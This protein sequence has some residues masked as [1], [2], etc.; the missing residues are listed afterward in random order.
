MTHQSIHPS[1]L[2]ELSARI[3][4]RDRQVL[5]DLGRVRLATA[6]Q[7]Q[8]L[9]HGPADDDAARH[10]RLRQLK[11]LTRLGLTT[12]LHRRVG[13][14]EAGSASTIYALDIAGQRIAEMHSGTRKRRPSTPSTPFITHTVTITE[15]YVQLREAE[16]R[17][18]LDLVD[19]EAEPAA[20]RS[21]HDH[22]GQPAMLK[23][24]AYAAVADGQFEQHVFIEVD[25]DTT[26]PG[27]LTVKGQ[28]YVDYYAT[29][30][31]QRRLGVFPAVLWVT[32]SERRADVIRDALRPFGSFGFAVTLAETFV[33][34]LTG[35]AA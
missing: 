2:S 24:D 28:R 16:R 15:L 8:R 11:R 7:L 32:T 12:P 21:Y 1:R 10:R 14:L 34:A 13:G 27:R 17:G 23:P 33:E 19:F 35:N 20:W 31:E 6:V 18:D 3:D 22:G 4:D 26:A 25:L 30:L 9:H 29:R 5:A